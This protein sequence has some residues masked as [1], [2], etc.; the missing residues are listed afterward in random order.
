V[1]RADPAIEAAEA[2][3]PPYARRLR[4]EGSGDPKTGWPVA[5]EGRIWVESRLSRPGGCQGRAADRQGAWGSTGGDRGDR[6]PSGPNS[7]AVNRPGF[8]GGPNR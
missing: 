4:P 8:A 3:S 2:G 6:L 5:Y 7:A 1:G